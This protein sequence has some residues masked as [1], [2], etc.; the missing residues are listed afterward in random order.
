MNWFFVLAGFAWGISIA[1][2]IYAWHKD[3]NAPICVM[4]NW[5]W[6]DDGK[7][8]YCINCGRKAGDN[9]N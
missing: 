3:T 2:R 6:S 1:I 5:Q 7:V 9:G 4:H 8:L